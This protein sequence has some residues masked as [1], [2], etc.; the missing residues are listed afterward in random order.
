MANV[1]FIIFE[2]RIAIKQEK[3]QLRENYPGDAF[4]S[5][6]FRFAIDKTKRSD[7]TS[8]S[9]FITCVAFG[10]L[11]DFICN[12]CKRGTPL[13]V[14]GRVSNNREGDVEFL[15]DTAKIINV[16]RGDTT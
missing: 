5:C 8:V 15:L 4:A 14:T 2:G 12:H 11:A 1:N 13:L 16:S 10:P 3:V 7:G 6:S 9:D